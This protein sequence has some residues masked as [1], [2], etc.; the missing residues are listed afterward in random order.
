MK[1]A[2][3]AAYR[4]PR[5]LIHGIRGLRPR[6]LQLPQPLHV[7]AVAVPRRIMMKTAVVGWLS[8]AADHMII[9]NNTM[10]D[11]IMRLNIWSTH[12]HMTTLTRTATA[13]RKV[14]RSV[15]PG[16]WTDLTR[17]WASVRIRLSV[18]AVARN[19]RRLEVRAGVRRR[20]RAAD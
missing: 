15:R 11:N 1:T 7:S 2:A 20:Q 17:R 13:V 5:S 10:A 12:R 6:L 18:V 19:K 14:R 16:R 9:R 4:P 3:V 8:A